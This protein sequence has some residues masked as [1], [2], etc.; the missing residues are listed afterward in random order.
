MAHLTDHFVPLRDRGFTGL[1]SLY[2][3]ASRVEDFELFVNVTWE[4][5][6][7]VDTDT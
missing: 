1:E 3:T 7:L 6:V 5:G 2:V 4:D